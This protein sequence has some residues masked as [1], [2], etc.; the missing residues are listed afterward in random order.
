MSARDPPTPH[1]GA[2]VYADGTGVDPI[3]ARVVPDHGADGVRLGGLGQLDADDTARTPC[4]AASADRR[5][6]EGRAV[7]RRHGLP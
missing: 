6:E 1:L 4:D 3:L 5:V 7:V 2:I